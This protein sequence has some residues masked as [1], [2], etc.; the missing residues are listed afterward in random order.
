MLY[1]FQK[2][3]CCAAHFIARKLWIA[4]LFLLDPS[5]PPLIG[6]RTHAW[7]FRQLQRP[8]PSQ[9]NM[10]RQC[11]VP[12]LYLEGENGRE[13]EREEERERERERKRETASG[14]VLPESRKR[15]PLERVCALLAERQ[16]QHL[17]VAVVYVPYS[18]DSGPVHRRPYVGVSRPRSWSHLLVLGAISWA[19]IAKY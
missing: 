11:K 17:A 13:R 3:S 1:Y 7:R 18:P 10:P 19:F 16:G 14:V 8:T 5:T 4:I 6:S 2:R 9:A 12:P 15:E